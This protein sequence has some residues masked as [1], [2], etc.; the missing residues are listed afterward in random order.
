MIV[1]IVNVLT[2]G[3]P[4]AEQKVKADFAQRVLSLVQVV[5]VWRCNSQSTAAED[6]SAADKTIDSKHVTV[7]PR[8]LLEKNIGVPFMVVCTNTEAMV[9][10]CAACEIRPSPSS[11]AKAPWISSSGPSAGSHC[12][13]RSDGG[14]HRRCGISGLCELAEEE[15][16]SSRSLA[17]PIRLLPATLH[18]PSRRCRRPFLP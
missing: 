1:K 7:L 17:H 3:N 12:N 13:V 4:E 5:M 15:V 9:V 8:G 18:F 16:D 10:S 11:L 2:K 6:D 14:V